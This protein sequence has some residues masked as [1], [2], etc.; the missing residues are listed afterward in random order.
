M[1]PNLILVSSDSHAGAPWYVYSDYLDP[2]H[3]DSWERWSAKHQGTGDA[4]VAPIQTAT[5]ADQRR[6][7]FLRELDESRGHLGNW[8]FD[9]RVRELDRDG[10]SGEVIF[11]DGSMNNAPPFGVGIF[12]L[13]EQASYE[14]RRA[15]CRAHNRWLAEQCATNPGRH[16]GIALAPFENPE[17]AV[18]EIRWASA[19]GLR[20]GV[21]LP[22]LQ[23]RTNGAE[24]FYDHP[25]YEPIWAV[26][27]ELGMVLNVHATN[28]IVD[29]GKTKL[30][31]GIEN[32]WTTY[33]PFWF[34]LWS[35]VFERHPGLK[36]VFTESGGLQVGWITRYLDYLAQTRRTAEAKA[37]LSMP[38]SEY[39]AKH[40]AV[41][42]S[43]HASRAEIDDRYIIG[44]DN[45]LWGSDYPHPEGSW[46]ESEKALNE[47]LE[48]LPET[49]IRRIAGEN[50]ARVYGMD[51]EYLRKTADKIG[52]SAF[53]SV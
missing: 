24:N 14:E 6:S 46:P 53:G 31:R 25:R 9:I 50:A 40:C 22:G 36:I 21:L 18:E 13:R 39:W 42:A 47:L 23:L 29:Y 48:G 27:E 8:D 32:H 20:G 30:V 45:I 3:R 41:G 16:A 43:A 11:C 26:C 15:G 4:T 12:M 5:M 19:N 44:V 28:S 35:G 38:P 34:L 17:D 37:V 49:E 51:I 1:P 7:S 33:R 2:Q 52:P 10:I